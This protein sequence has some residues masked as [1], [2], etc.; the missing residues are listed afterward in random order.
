MSE[1]VDL[2]RSLFAHWER[3]DFFT[4]TEWAHPEI[5][6]VMADGPTPGHWT[7]V[8]G[9]VEGFRGWLGVWDEFRVEVDEYRQ[10]DTERVL[11][12]AHGAGRG[13]T[14]GL[15]ARQIRTH[16]A[17]VLRVSDRKVTSLVWYLDRERALADLGLAE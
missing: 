12:L 3:G 7:G 13:K 14:S 6:F 8:A 4:D 15:D 1:N 2:V 5:E 9:A 10:L 17:A 16:G 11:V